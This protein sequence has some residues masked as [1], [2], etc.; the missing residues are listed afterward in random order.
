MKKLPVVLV[1]AS[2]AAAVAVATTRTDGN[3]PSTSATEGRSMHS[4]QPQGQKPPA[5]AQA[6]SKNSIPK[7][8]RKQMEMAMAPY[9]KAQMAAHRL[10]REGKVKQAEVECRRA[11]AL[12]PQVNGKPWDDVEVQLLGDILLE[13]GRNQEALECYLRRVTSSKP[14]DPKYPQPNLGAALAYCRLGNFE[15]A[16]RYY[17]LA[18]SPK[19]RKSFPGGDHAF[20]AS[21]L[22][23]RAGEE[24]STANSRGA[25]SYLKQ[26]EKLAP[27][28]WLIAYR[29][30]RSLLYLNRPAESDR[31]YKRAVRF[32]GAKVP[33]NSSG[34]VVVHEHK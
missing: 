22:Y 3:E 34:G 32:G 23:S 27:T 7:D 10:M 12:A 31:Y 2:L 29:I 1:I 25:L 21:L 4:N 17:P 11:I 9:N 26:A 19:W 15:L 6:V 24:D 16:K 20:E 33:S 8:V 18:N 5:E 14:D 13:E 28:N 30:S